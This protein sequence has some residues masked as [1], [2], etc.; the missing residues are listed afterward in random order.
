[1]E[2]TMTNES[3]PTARIDVDRIIDLVQKYGEYSMDIGVYDK[4]TTE[5]TESFKAMIYAFAD[6]L[7]LLQG[8]EPPTHE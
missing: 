3:E 6:M 7:C 4:D 8:K 1:M 5:Y 2:S